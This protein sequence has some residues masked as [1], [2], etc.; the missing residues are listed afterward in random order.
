MKTEDLIAN[1]N[2]FLSEIQDKKERLLA[3]ARKKDLLAMYDGEDKIIYSI[4]YAKELLTLPPLDVFSTGIESLDEKIGGGISPGQLVTISGITK[5]G[6]TTMSKFL[7]RNMESLYPTFF[8]FEESVAEL[9]LKEV[10]FKNTIPKFY[11]PRTYDRTDDLQWIE[12]KILES[13]IKYGSKVVFIDHLGFLCDE[14]NVRERF[15]LKIQGVMR[16]IK[17]M[18]RELNV[19]IVL[20]CHLRKIQIDKAPTLDDIADSKAIPQL[21]D[22]VWC[23][24]RETT[25]DDMGKTQLTDFTNFG[26][27]A[28]RQTGSVSNILFSFDR[29]NYTEVKSEFIEPKKPAFKYESR[30]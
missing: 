23:V 2:K 30:K 8:S 26:I 20:L 3:E 22:K 17:L 21:S 15:D 5:H 6:K 11:F 19:A 18:A 9:L 10:K 25:R 14:S 13:I 24:W 28:D 12:N 7:M 1:A 27:L 4:D 29:G 16:K